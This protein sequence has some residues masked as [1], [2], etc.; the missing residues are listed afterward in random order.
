[1]QTSR[2]DLQSQ[3]EQRIRTMRTIWIALVLSIGS[4]YVLTL[5]AGQPEEKPNTALSVALLAFGL[6]MVP[7]SF[8][9]KNKILRQAAEQQRASLVQQ[10]YIVAWAIIEIAALLGVFDFFVTGHRHYFLLFII[11]VCGQLLHFPRR[12]HLL[13]ASFKQP[14]W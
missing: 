11:A 1:M 5:V 8:V 13:D 10:A 12:Q 7:L 2:N 4:Y 14:M 3:I 9:I 6:L